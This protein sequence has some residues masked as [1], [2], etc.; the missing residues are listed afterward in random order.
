[1]PQWEWLSRVRLLAGL[2]FAV[3]LAVGVHFSFSEL[4]A[5]GFIGPNKTYTLDADFD[6]GVLFNVNHDAPNNNQLQL[7]ETLTT[8]PVMWIANAGEDTVS[9]ID[10]NTGREL[11]RYRTWFGPAGQP[12][13]VP[14]LGNAYAGAAPSRTGVDTDGHLYIANR[15]FDNRPGDV[16]KILTEGGIDRN[17][18]GTIDTSS[19]LDNNG[20]ISGAE[21][22]PMGD[23]NGNGIIE[24]NEVQDER[25]VWVVRVGANNGLGRSLCLD[26]NGDP[27][28]GLYNSLQYFKLDATTG[29][30]L[31]GPINTFLPGATNN[32]YGCLV[33]ANGILWGASLGTTLLRLDTNTNT[34]TNIFNH[35]AFGGDYGIAL[36]NGVVYQG[37]FGNGWIRFDP[38]TGMFTKPHAVNHFAHGVATDASGFIYTANGSSG[39]TKWTDAGAIV[40]TAPGQPG[41]GA[42]CWGVQ[43]DSEGDAWCIP[44]DANFISKYD[45]ATGGALGVFP[46]G[47]T[48]YTYS[49]ATGIS[50]FSTTNPTG[51]WTIVQDSGTAGNAWDKIT[52]NTEPQGNEPAGT[53]ITVEARVAETEA[54]L[55]GQAYVPVTNGGVLPLTGRYIDVR[56]TLTSNDPD[57]SPVL[58][59]LSITSEV[60]STVC[61]IDVDGDVD[62]ADLVLI[63][64]AYQQTPAPGDP[65]DANG[66]GK[67]NVADTRYCALRCTLPGCAT[68]PGGGG[69]PPPPP[70]TR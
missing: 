17:G 51:R 22:L 10:T 59:D 16:L 34:V 4:K 43:I 57:T 44:R 64:A 49:D 37:V 39:L 48:P 67:I 62:S 42:F 52:W 11:A 3:V 8:F 7:N 38:V 9:K 32:P 60:T 18:N 65:K 27:W 13:H 68:G 69:A 41:Q 55:A 6:L 15:H 24:M 63:R 23:T 19:D 20:V 40:W 58:S 35:A 61:D 53:A 30:Q 25:V 12:G 46:V 29:A 45:G 14:H 31:V 21:I 1:M 54:G 33:D 36:G 28:A 70:P 66:D 26:T 50:G 47:N 2:G 56:A 5:A